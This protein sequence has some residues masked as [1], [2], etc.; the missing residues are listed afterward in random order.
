MSIRQQLAVLLATATVA[1]IILGGTAHHQFE[2]NN[3]LIHELTEGA[4]P[5]FLAASELGSRLKSVQISTMGLVAA[6]TDGIAEQSKAKVELA[7]Q[8]LAQELQAQMRIADGAAQEGLVRQA[9][10]SM[11]NYFGAIDDVIALRLSG[12]QVL[13][14]AALDGTVGP[15]LQ[16]LEQILETL[17]VEKRRAK[18][19]S[20]ATMET[21]LQDSAT[22]LAIAAALTMVV[23]GT[24]GYRLYRQIVRPLREMEQTMAEIATTLDFTRRVPVKRRDEIGQSL[25][26]FNSL[27]D[28][29]QSSL[30]EMVQVIRDNE[31]AA[32]AMHESA[33]VL[34][35]IALSGHASSKDIQAAV[36]EIQAQI[37]HIHHNTRQAGGLTE[38]SGQQAT[39]NGEVIRE[40]VDRIHSLSRSVEAAADKVFA[41]A[42]AG[43]NIAGQIKEIREIADQTNLLALN[44]AI[45][46]ARAGETGRGFAVVADEVRK[47]AERVTAATQS[48]TRQV[49]EI[50]TTSSL[51]TEL[52]RQ[53]VG[54]MNLN[55][56][57]TRSAGSAMT[58]IESSA[59]QVVSVVEEIGQQVSVGQ[60]SSQEIVERV[61]TIDEL[62]TKANVAAGHTRDFAD[63]IR[64][65][66]DRM[67]GIVNR[68]RIGDARFA[69]STGNAGR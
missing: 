34:A 51:S 2:R 11:K 48:I 6:P 49:A 60:A 40:A 31:V 59:R 61:D 47:L 52:M 41:L 25:A 64:G 35:E 62:I 26:A 50:D 22:T 7:R 67:A 38:Q 10:E 14:E 54:D 32:N 29:L 36:K 21:S 1:L 18:D 57:L 68:F 42:A 44:A 56:D 8:S 43:R 45:E 30:Y 3:A 17:S 53:V 19:R 63:R 28:T 58:A 46:A 9:Q 16:E 39:A 15:Y 4:I 12:Q 24:L 69:A 13:A 37:D 20:V 5:G 65:L 66:S 33:V 27:V 23:L 55:I